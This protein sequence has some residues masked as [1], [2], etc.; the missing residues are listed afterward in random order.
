MQQTPSV[1]FLLNIL[2]P[3]S[4]RDLLKVTH[5][6]KK[7]HKLVYDNCQMGIMKEDMPDRKLKIK[8][9]EF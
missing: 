9:A 3:L 1:Y 5:L 4:G 6:N 7:M 2:R 8:A